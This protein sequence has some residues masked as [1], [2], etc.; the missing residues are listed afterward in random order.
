MASEEP[1]HWEQQLRD[2]AA[3]AEEEVRRVVTYINDEV[4]PDIRK[5]GS[6]AL[7]KASVELQKL[8]QRMEERSAADK[9]EPKS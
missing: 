5:N 3:R 1:K 4:V 9:D 6:Q 8:A 2:A 7:R